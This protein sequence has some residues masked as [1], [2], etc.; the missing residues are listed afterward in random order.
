MKRKVFFSFH[1]Q[2]DNSR[3]SQ[4][5]NIGRIEGNTPVSDNDWESVTKGGNSAIIRWIESQL[6]G[7]SCTVV[8]IGENT[9]GRRWIDY[10]IEKSWN[11]GKGVLGI[12]IHKL[13]NLAGEQSRKGKN[14]FASIAFKNGKKLSD[15]V[16]DYDPPFS[17][18]KDVYGYVASNI[19]E[20]IEEAIEIRKNIIS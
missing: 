11:D 17:N 4:I 14:P 16:K 12:Y 13:K 5:R 7:R 20:W 19:S 3:A 1:Y 8:L 6:I 9:A 2:P 15:V 10:E 18:S